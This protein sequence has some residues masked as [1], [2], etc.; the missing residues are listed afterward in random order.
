MPSSSHKTLSVLDLYTPATPV[1]TVEAIAARFGC[2]IATAYRYVGDLAAA[3]LLTRVTGGSYVLGPRIVELDLLMRE[4]DPI[5]AAGRP[6]IDTLVADTGCDVLLSNIYGDHLVNVMHVRGTEQLPISFVRGRP[7]PRFRGAMAK[8]ILAF[9]ARSRL[10]RIHKLHATEIRAAGLGED[11][12]DFWRTLQVIRKRGYA[13]S[14]GELDP[15]VV[16]LA[17]PVFNGPD[18][19]GSVGLALSERR[20]RLLNVERLAAMVVEC[21]ARVSR[22]IEGIAHPKTAVMRPRRSSSRSGRR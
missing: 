20:V 19:L 17:A 1:W 22:S 4:V 7:H 12:I 5:A 3:G 2:S 14:L 11:W 21:A 16:G 8:A 18:V 13:E 15:G 9:M 6:L 10:A